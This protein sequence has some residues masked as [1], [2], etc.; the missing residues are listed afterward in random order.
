MLPHEASGNET[1]RNASLSGNETDNS[2]W[3]DVTCAT[4]SSDSV[5]A[6]PFFHFGVYFMYLVIFLLALIGNALVCYVVQSSPRMKTVTNYFIMNL[7]IG[8]ILMTLLCIPFSFVSMLLLRYWPFGM[9]MCKIVNY[10]QAV[11]VFVSAYTLLAISIDRYMVIMR[12]LKPRLGKTAAKLVIATVWAGAMATAAP[13]SIVSQTERPSG[14]HEFCQLDICLEHW[15]HVEQS[16]QYTCALLVLQFGLPLSALVC[17]YTRIAQ[18]VWGGRP[19]GEAESSRDHRIRQSKRKMVKMMVTVVVVFTVSWLPLNIFIMLWTVH[20]EE[21]AVW[22]GAPYVWFA[23]HWLAMS[24]SCYNPII[25]CYMNARFRHGFRQVLSC[26]IG[27]QLSQPLQTCQRL[28][29]CEGVPMSDFMCENGTSRR[30]TG[31]SFTSRARVP[32]TCASLRRE[33]S[34]L[35]TIAPPTAPPVRA[36]SVR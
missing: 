29:L 28:S 3:Y 26:V 10:S 12:P 5:L 33:P 8:D 19:P 18:V 4:S 16:T 24:H 32:S 15:D 23:C 22:A 20:E 30:G 14:W 34:R 2:T 36:L 1:S 35:A 21:W 31:S 13:I 6:S 17:T 27:D 11:S 7:A 25:Y 9:V